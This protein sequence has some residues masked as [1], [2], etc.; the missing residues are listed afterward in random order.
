MVLKNERILLRGQSDRFLSANEHRK[1]VWKTISKK[2]FE[3]FDVALTPKQVQQHF[4]NRK[5]K[6]LS[7]EIREKKEEN[8]SKT[9]FELKSY[10]NQRTTARGLPNADTLRVNEWHGKEKG[11][12]DELLVGHSEQRN[13][14]KKGER[15]AGG[16][17]SNESSACTSLESFNQIDALV[18]S[19]VSD[20]ELGESESCVNEKSNKTFECFQNSLNEKLDKA[21]EYFRTMLQEQTRM[22]EAVIQMAELQKRGLESI[23]EFTKPKA[24]SKKETKL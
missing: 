7:L 9:E 13:H 3:K 5:R 10:Y 4:N 12:K 18:D 8:V 14:V 16:S 21:L 1:D 2:L 6:P 23:L 17:R 22:C 15:M 24:N 19:D 11:K 20:E